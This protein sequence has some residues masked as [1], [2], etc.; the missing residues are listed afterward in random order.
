MAAR[1]LTAIARVRDFL[2]SRA[3]WLSL[4][5][6][7]DAAKQ[8]K[9]LPLRDLHGED[10]DPRVGAGDATRTT[11]PAIRESAGLRMTLSDGVALDGSLPSMLS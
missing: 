5:P 4:P 6:L 2:I 10:V 3:G 11:L 7:V 8:L 9:L 1:Q